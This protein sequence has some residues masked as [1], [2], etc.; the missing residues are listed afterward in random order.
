[1]MMLFALLKVAATGSM[2]APVFGFTFTAD[3]GVGMGY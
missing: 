2:S 3:V 1:L